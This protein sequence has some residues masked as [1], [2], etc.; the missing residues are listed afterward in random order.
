MLKLGFDP[1]KYVKKRLMVANLGLITFYVFIMVAS[2]FLLLR[3]L[4]GETLQ[5]F[6]ISYCVNNTYTTL[7]SMGFCLILHAAYR[8]FDTIN[9]CIKHNFKTEEEDVQKVFARNS[10]S[11]QRLIIKLADLHDALNDCVVDINRCYCLE[12]GGF[13]FILKQI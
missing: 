4:S 7:F 3:V 12:V 5:P 6:I 13:V 11:P 1:N 9:D 8:R 2:L 10:L